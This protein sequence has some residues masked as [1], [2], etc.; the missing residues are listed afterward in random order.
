MGRIV[1]EIK[2]RALHLRQHSLFSSFPISIGRSY[3]S[4]VIIPDPYVCLEHLQIREKEDGKWEITDLDSKN[5]IFL[6]NKKT[7]DKLV[8]IK[9]GDRIRIGHT[10][11]KFVSPEEPQA[12]TILIKRGF[13]N[14][15]GPFLIGSAWASLLLCFLYLFIEEYVG[16]TTKVSI[17]K[18]ISESIAPAFIP[19]IWASIWSAIGRISKHHAYFHEQ[20]LISSI[21]FSVMMLIQTTVE[22]VEFYS[23][24]DFGATIFRY[25]LEAALFLTLLHENFRIATQFKGRVLKIYALIVTLIIMGL[26]T[27]EILASKADFNDSPVYSKIL[28]P[29]FF[30]ILPSTSKDKFFKDCSDL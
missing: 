5:G 7:N 30:R 1:I 3:E 18:V 17:S 22:Y 4:D 26:S 11:L 25:I 9:S 13:L 24:S 16:T 14:P 27:I 2:N 12:E 10:L 23:S 8:E 20:L 29:P 15:E 6:N 28:K 19:L 21:G